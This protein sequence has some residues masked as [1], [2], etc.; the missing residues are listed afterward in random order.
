MGMQ[1]TCTISRKSKKNASTALTVFGNTAQS[2]FVSPLW[3]TKL[4]VRQ[5]L[6]VL[7]GWFCLNRD[8]GRSVWC[9]HDPAQWQPG[10]T[11]GTPLAFT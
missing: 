10:V 2:S 5:V 1:I 4:L 9:Q 8:E 11:P 6:V 7:A 3:T